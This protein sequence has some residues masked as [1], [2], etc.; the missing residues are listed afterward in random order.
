MWC[1]RLNVHGELI[2]LVYFFSTTSNLFVQCT[3]AIHRLVCATGGCDTSKINDVMVCINWDSYV[4]TMGYIKHC[5][6]ISSIFN[7]EKC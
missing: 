4:V 7:R 2:S 1:K 3:F 6:D 5:K